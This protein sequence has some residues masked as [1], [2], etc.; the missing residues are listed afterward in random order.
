MDKFIN[1]ISQNYILSCIIMAVIGGGLLFAAIKT[2]KLSLFILCAVCSAISALIT[3][4]IETGG[5]DITRSFVILFFVVMHIGVLIAAFAL[6]L[7]N[8][9]RNIIKIKS[10]ENTKDILI[11]LGVIAVLILWVISIAE[12]FSTS[13]RF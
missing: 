7:T 11:V 12:A 1:L 5:L 4:S 6:R 9:I 8:E 13:T 3:N 2:K 10:W